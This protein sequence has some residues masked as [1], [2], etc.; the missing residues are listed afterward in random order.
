MSFFSE[1]VIWCQHGSGFLTIR[2]ASVD[3]VFDPSSL[4]SF[5]NILVLLLMWHGLPRHIRKKH[6]SVNDCKVFCQ[7]ILI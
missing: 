7:P 6:E 1:D 2:N 3:D 5:D 4:D